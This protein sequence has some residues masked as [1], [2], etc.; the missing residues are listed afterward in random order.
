MNNT[1]TNAISALVL[2]KSGEAIS[3][4][5]GRRN[6]VV[7]MEMKDKLAYVGGM[8]AMKR[9]NLMSEYLVYMAKHGTCWAEYTYKKD[10]MAAVNALETNG[11]TIR[12]KQ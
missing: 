4:V 12:W 1:F 9:H 8:G 6:Y 10:F 2:A 11:F 7:R 5:R 3:K